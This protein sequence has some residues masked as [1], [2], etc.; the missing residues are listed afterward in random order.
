MTQA[1]EKLQE[2]WKEVI[3]NPKY[4]KL[5]PVR[6][7]SLAIELE[8]SVNEGCLTTAKRINEEF[9]LLKEEFPT[10]NMGASS[11]T[12]GTGNIDTFD[13]IL[14]SL[15]RR[16]APNLIAY[17]LCGV[18][19]MTGPTGLVFALRTR[20]GSM[21]GTEN[22]YNEVNTGWSGWPGANMTS[23]GAGSTISGGY[24]NNTVP[25]GANGNLSGVPGVSNNAGN[26]TYNYAGGMTTAGAEGLGYGNSVF[27][28]MGFSIEK[29]T[30]TARERGLKA[31]YSIELAQDLKAVHGLDA[32]AELTNLL[33]TELLAEINREVIRTIVVAAKPGA[34]TGTTTA[35][36]FDLDVDADGRWLIE[37]FKGL[38]FR[39]DLE[40]NAIAKATRRGKGNVILCSSNVA[41]ALMAAGY[42]QYTP[43]LDGNNLFI[44]DT[45]NT[46]AG[47]LNNKYKVYID[48]YATGDYIVMG[49]KGANAF[50][51]G[52][53]YCPYVPLQ[54]LKAQDP[55]TF[56]PKVAFKTRY[57][58]VSNP[59]AEGLTVGQGRI[60]QDSNVFYSRTLISNIM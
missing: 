10:N 16:T 43:R 29:T 53:F 18:Q 60:T 33:S 17:D 52:I 1:I 46:F 15:M 39:L 31:E 25:G 11:S 36:I 2:K 56:Q 13:P 47:T 22:F 40:A 8:N 45:G 21:T 50:E 55:N 49:Y 14:I 5:S 37:K 35:G 34:Q 58:M 59:F 54:L 48:P 41:S 3:E 57:G 24:A 12:S 28:E 9:G 19:P 20:Y 44:D 6:A 27:P 4:G 51:A 32:Q 23:N 42:L 30:V 38:M 7:R 26:S